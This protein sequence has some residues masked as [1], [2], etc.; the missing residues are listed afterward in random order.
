MSGI[1]SCLLQSESDMDFARLGTIGYT[2]F[3]LMSSTAREHLQLFNLSS[4]TSKVV[5]MLLYFLDW[6]VLQLDNCRR[7][8]DL[9]VAKPSMI[10]HLLQSFCLLLALQ[11][12]LLH[13]LKSFEAKLSKKLCE[14]L[15]TRLILPVWT[16]YRSLHETEI[17]LEQH[18]K[19]HCVC[20]EFYRCIILQSAEY[21][22]VPAFVNS[23]DQ[24]FQSD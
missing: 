17:Y 8:G 15:V 12:L 21:V 6:H 19:P 16:D 7:E 22:V 23:L 13:L 24:Y 2:Q 9:K 10:S 4:R 1:Y 18:L 20:K 5:V 14:F 3:W 11:Q